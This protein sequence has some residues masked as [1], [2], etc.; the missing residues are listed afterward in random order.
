VSTVK[1]QGGAQSCTAHA[2]ILCYETEH[3]IK[4]GEHFWIE[5]SEQH[6]Y[7]KSRNYGGLFP[8][9]GGAYLRDACKALAKIGMCPEKLMPYNDSDINSP[10]GIM[11]D[12]MAN[13]WKIKEYLRITSITDMKKALSD[14]HP[15]MIGTP[16]Y[17]NWRGLNSDTI[18]LPE[19]PSIGGHA[20]L[21]IGH[22]DNKAAFRIQNSWGR[23]WGDS[24]RAWL[25]Y[26]YFVHIDWFDA[27]TVRI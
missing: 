10:P 20:Y 7:Y 14:K 21:I 23:Q 3:F 25:P 16:V 2:A 11:T 17:Q 8:N 15:V 22:D 27:W 6:N 12:V 9:D 19:G 4:N 24:G 18:P 1:N 13:L 26:E 5:G